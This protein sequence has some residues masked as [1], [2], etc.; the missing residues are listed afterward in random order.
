MARAIS[1]TEITPYNS[2]VGSTTNLVE[3][4]FKNLMKYKGAANDL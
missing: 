1:S 3:R 4:K 2:P